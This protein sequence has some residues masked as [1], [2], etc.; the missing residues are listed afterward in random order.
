MYS[1]FFAYLKPVLFH[2]FCNCEI[3]CTYPYCWAS[4]WLCWLG[5]KSICRQPLFWYFLYVVAY[6]A[7]KQ[8]FECS[9]DLPFLQTWLC[10]ENWVFEFCFRSA[11]LIVLFLK[12]LLKLARNTLGSPLIDGKYVFGILRYFIVK[13]H[14]H[15]YFNTFGLKWS[16]I[17]LLNVQ[18][19]GDVII[20]NKVKI[21]D[22]SVAQR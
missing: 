6:S 2:I 18:L 13:W 15:I 11:F 5:I 3:Q 7:F 17:L 12:Y 20:C 9:I 21:Q 22:D 10:H 19:F 1:V 16:A 14:S 8:W 4:L